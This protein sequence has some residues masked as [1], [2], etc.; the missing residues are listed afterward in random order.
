MYGVFRQTKP[1]KTVHSLMRDKRMTVYRGQ[2][3]NTLEFIGLTDTYK[4]SF[5]LNLRS[6]LRQTF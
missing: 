2:T 3:Q 5:S 4:V 6:V 1:S